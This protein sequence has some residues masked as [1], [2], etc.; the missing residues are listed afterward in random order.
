MRRII[1][2]DDDPKELAHAESLGVTS[3]ALAQPWNKSWRGARAE[4]WSELR[5]LLSNSD[6][7]TPTPE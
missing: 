4:N 1:F 3:I 2:V 5:D 7:T 6:R